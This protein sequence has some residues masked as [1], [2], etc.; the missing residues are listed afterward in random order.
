ML[1]AGGDDFIDDENEVLNG[2]RKRRE[3]TK[4]N[5]CLRAF[6]FC[7]DKYLPLGSDIHKISV[8]LSL[9]SIK[10]IVVL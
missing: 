8:K 1:N 3:R 7:L 10:N 9:I 6:N 4:C 2:E 5:K